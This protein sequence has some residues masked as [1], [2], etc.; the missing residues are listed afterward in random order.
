[1]H[2]IVCDGWSIGVLVREMTA[3]YNAYRE[4][5]ESPL[6]EPKLQYA[7]YACW[8][9]ELL[10]GAGLVSE[11]DY[12]KKQLR[13]APS[14]VELPT[15]STRPHRSVHRGSTE[16]LSFS[17]EMTSR[18]RSLSRQYDATVFMTLLA[19]FNILLSRYTHQ[20]EIIVGTNIA[21]RNRREIE[22]MVGFFVNNLPLRARLIGS[23][24]FKQFLGEIKQICL[25]AQA[26]QDLPF[27][28]LVEE[29]HPQRVPNRHPI[30]QT[31][32]VLQNPRDEIINLAGGLKL[33]VVELDAAFTPYDLMFNLREVDG[34][35]KGV[36]HYSAELYE[37][38]SIQR[39]LERYNSLLENILDHPDR[40]LDSYRVSMD[41]EVSDLIRDFNQM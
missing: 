38:V 25:E 40:P 27:D 21:S 5:R 32:F 4:G 39:L 7:D 10:Q 33:E 37:A 20:D 15:A 16:R 14:P 18:I 17:P 22:G 23:Q 12:W 24:T 41:E 35:L 29:L 3:L 8:Q 30:F 13:G 36:L 1:M 2:H 11:I 26:H 31:L 19:A 34:V 9:R 6:E 28:K